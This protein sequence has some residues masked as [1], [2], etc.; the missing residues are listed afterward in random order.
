MARD[1]KAVDIVTGL[2]GRISAPG[3]GIV[4]ASVAVQLSVDASDGGNVIRYPANGP[5]TSVII[6]N[7]GG[8]D[9]TSQIIGASF[10]SGWSLTGNWSGSLVFGS[11]DTYTIRLSTSSGTSTASINIRP[12]SIGADLAAAINERN[13]V[14]GITTN[15][16]GTEGAVTLRS[17]AISAAVDYVDGSVASDGTATL[18][19]ASDNML[20]IPAATETTAWYAA[21]Y[22]AI[23]GVVTKAESCEAG[24]RR[25][26]SS[27]AFAYDDAV[28]NEE[29]QQYDGGG[30][31]ADAKSQAE[32]AFNANKTVSDWEGGINYTAGASGY[33]AREYG[34]WRANCSTST[35]DWRVRA[36]GVSPFS[37]SMDVYFTAGKPEYSTYNTLGDHD[38][39]NGQT[40]KLVTVTVAAN[41]SGAW[42][43]HINSISVHWGNS[44]GYTLY[45]RACWVTY[46]FAHT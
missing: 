1:S 43:E 34:N 9:V 10:S 3:S 18:Y 28:W 44:I 46:G 40:G 16:T 14:K 45:M 35:Y 32:S 6:R 17:A 23:C 36:S 2:R 41:S 25:R 30:S 26:A 12:P 8:S 27:G 7:S 13:L 33:T 21:A 5:G 22:A 42:A 39:T 19:N 4:G 20:D 29:T 24:M 37:R 38:L 11:A 31:E 15:Y